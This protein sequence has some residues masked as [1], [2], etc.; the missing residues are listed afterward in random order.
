MVGR[1][2]HLLRTAKK[3]GADWNLERTAAVE[4]MDR[5]TKKQKAFVVVELSFDNGVYP[6]CDVFKTAWDK[7]Q[8]LSHGN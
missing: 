3:F 1:L 7:F 2:C 5:N 8:D 4:G 6:E